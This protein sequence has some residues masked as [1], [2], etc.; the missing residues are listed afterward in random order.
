MFST[1]RKSVDA[2]ACGLIIT[3]LNRWVTVLRRQNFYKTEWIPIFTESPLHTETMPELWD[4]PVTETTRR[5]ALEALC[6]SRSDNR[7][8]ESSN[9][10]SKMKMNLHRWQK[11]TIIYAKLKIF[12]HGGSNPHKHVSVYDTLGFFRK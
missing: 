6:S 11:S 3:A 2:T 8:L 7:L 9:L 5:P 10:W 4:A 1:E 12:T